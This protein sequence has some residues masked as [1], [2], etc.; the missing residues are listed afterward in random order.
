MKRLLTTILAIN[1][2]TLTAFAGGITAKTASATQGT[3]EKD[4]LV[5]PSTYEQYLPLSAPS[6]V[7]VSQNFTAIADGNS[8]YLYDRRNASYHC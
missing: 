5:Y 3:E 7:A 2:L 8:V 1:T 6:D 4:Y